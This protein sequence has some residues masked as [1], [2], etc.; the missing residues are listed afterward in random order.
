M[1]LPNPIKL[2]QD[3]FVRTCVKSLRARI[4]TVKSKEEEQVLATKSL[5]EVG[6]YRVSALNSTHNSD[7]KVK[8]STKDKTLDV[9]GV[10]VKLTAKALSIYLF[11]VNK[12]MRT[13]TQ[14]RSFEEDVEQTREY[15]EV[16][17]SMK[18]DVRL[19]RSMGLEDEGQ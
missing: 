19:Y 7:V 15:L 10:S 17:D 16:L 9:A 3:Q 2:S 12:G 14:G 5:D 4:D 6:E 11:F 1:Q 8:I 18:A 13:E